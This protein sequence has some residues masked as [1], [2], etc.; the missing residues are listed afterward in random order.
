[1]GNSGAP[2]SASGLLFPGNPLRQQLFRSWGNGGIAGGTKKGSPNTE[3]IACLHRLYCLYHLYHL[4]H[5]YTCTA[6]LS[7]QAQQP[8]KKKLPSSGKYRQNPP[9]KGTQTASQRPR[10]GIVGYRVARLMQVLCHGR[11]PKTLFASKRSTILPLGLAEN[12]LQE[13]LE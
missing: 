2:T 9:R 10:F 6:F 5:L 7:R 3:L 4:Y 11:G 13:S 12:P 8:K 1:M